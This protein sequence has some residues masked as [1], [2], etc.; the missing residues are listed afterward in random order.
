MVTETGY[1]CLLKQVIGGHWNMLLHLTETCY[2]CHWNRLL[3]LIE[4]GTAV[5]WIRLLLLIETGYCCHRNLF[6]LVIETQN[7]DVTTA[8]F[9]S[10]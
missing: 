2:F 10:F 8:G 1:C 7:F 9:I 4:T 3:L 5:H 6:L